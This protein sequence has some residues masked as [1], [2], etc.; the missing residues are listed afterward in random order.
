MAV[1]LKTIQFSFPATATMANDTLTTL[2]QISVFLPETGTKT[3]R[4]AIVEISM[5][6]IVTATD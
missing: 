2:T 1:R 6:D 4:N 5:D 3:I